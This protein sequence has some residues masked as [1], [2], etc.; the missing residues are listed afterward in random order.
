[1]SFS[2]PHYLDACV[3][4]QLVC[5]ESGSQR[6][7]DYIRENENWSF[8]FCM[9][10]YAFYEVLGVLKRKWK[11]GELDDAQYTSA[12][13]TLE[14]YLEEIIEIDFDFKPHDRHLILE[15]GELVR[16]HGVDYSDALQIYTILN[17]KWKSNVH[18]C[19]TILVTADK[20]LV[21]AA[22][23]EGLRVWHFPDGEA[24]KSE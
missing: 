24:P 7:D 2:V 12:I 8:T 9:T 13:S 1:M 10:E 19:R 3:A 5:R 4:V 22:T 6:I 21:A 14:A 23:S 18:E 20:D 15:L 11:K 16:K 17:G